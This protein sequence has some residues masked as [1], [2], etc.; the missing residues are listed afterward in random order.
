MATED[1]LELAGSGGQP[2]GRGFYAHSLRAAM[3]SRISASRQH[4]PISAFAGGAHAHTILSSCCHALLPFFSTRSAGV[5]RVL[6]REAQATVADHGFSDSCT[7]INPRRLQQWRSSFPR[8][9]GARL[10]MLAGCRPC[11]VFSSFSWITTLCLQGLLQDIPASAFQSLPRLR[12]LNATHCCGLGDEALGHLLALEDLVMA[13]C[14][15]RSFAGRTLASLPRLRSLNVSGCTQLTDAAFAGLTALTSLCM[16]DCS[17]HAL[18]DEVLN[19]LP[20]LRTLHMA[21]C[22]QPTLTNAVFA[23]LA[24]ALQAVNINGCTQFTGGAL[25]HL[26]GVADLDLQGCRIGDGGFAHLRGAAPRR[27][28]LSGMRVTDE[29]LAHL[30][31]V[32]VLRMA[33]CNH[34]QL[35]DAA[36]APL[37]G[38]LE[39]LDMSGCNQ[40]TIT[41]ALVPLLAGVRVLRM[42]R[43]RDRVCKAAHA[44]GL[45][46]PP[47]RSDLRRQRERESAARSARYWEEHPLDW[48]EEGMEEGEGWE[49]EVEMDWWCRQKMAPGK[50]AGGKKSHR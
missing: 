10:R 11:A 48:R 39:E 18:T 38:G 35:T 24:G 44:A 36:F 46:V 12:A 27:L 29:A 31:G 22:R 13:G 5:L 40:A 7:P 34:P 45:P 30:N 25:R 37:A 15:Q 9:Q 26:R 21:R 6:C 3:F 28:N 8:A 4:S 49:E 41:E 20:I 14:T 2:P 19:D 17:Q 1:T 33:D 16:N 47:A 50:G 42:E 23:P 43:C 32:R